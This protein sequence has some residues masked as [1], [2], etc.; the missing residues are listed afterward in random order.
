[1]ASSVSYP[2][3]GEIITA[4]LFRLC[5]L[6]LLFFLTIFKHLKQSLNPY[7]LTRFY[8]TSTNSAKPDQILFY[9]FVALIRHFLLTILT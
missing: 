7:S 3:N 2:L 5:K 8:K 1:M 9:H 6:S 4:F